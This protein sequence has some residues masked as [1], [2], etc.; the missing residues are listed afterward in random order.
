MRIPNT[1]IIL[2]SVILLG[3]WG[4]AT[5]TP[6]LRPECPSLDADDYY[7]PQGALDPARPKIDGFLRNWYSKYLRAMLEPS[8]SCGARPEGFAYR[9]LWLRSFHHPIAMR[10]E[11]NGPSVMFNAVEL[12]GTGGNAP[13]GIVKSV[14]RELSSAEQSEF[15][16]KLARVDFWELGKNESRFG[17]D[18]AQWLLEGAE[19][20]QYRVVERWSPNPGPYRDVCLLLLEFTGIKIPPLDFY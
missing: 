1:I 5:K 17:L 6:A 2:V 20:G 8:L 18:G 10:V 12:D 4:C 9:F 15:L 7:F 13:G 11:K 14:Q 19:N 16:A 3:G